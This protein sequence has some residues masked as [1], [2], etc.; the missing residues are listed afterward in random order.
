MNANVEMGQFLFQL[1]LLTGHLVV[2]ECG[3]YGLEP[4]D[5]PG[6]VEYLF[7]NGDFHRVGGLVHGHVVGQQFLELLRILAGQE[8][9]MTG[10]AAVFEGVTR[11][12]FPCLG[13]LGTS[14]FGSV[15]AG[16]VGFFLRGHAVSPG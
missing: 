8:G 5:A 2:H 11:G 4:A 16:G 9:R 15:G 12:F 6:C 14:R 1:G 7:D 10:C 3:F 13:G